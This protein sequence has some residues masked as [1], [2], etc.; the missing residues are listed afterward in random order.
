MSVG[1]KQRKFS[2]LMHELEGFILDSGYEFTKGDAFRDPRVFGHI[3]E[4][5]GYGRANS[6]HKLKLAQDINLFKDKVYLTDTAD[7]EMFGVFWES[8]DPDCSWGGRFDDG[9][10]YSLTHNG[11]R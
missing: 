2:R 9:N 3:G 5:K 10:H 7:H 11:M 4:K 6:L 1:D 8:L